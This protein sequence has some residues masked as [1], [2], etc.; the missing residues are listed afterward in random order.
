M[1]LYLLKENNNLYD[2]EEGVIAVCTNVDKCI[3]LMNVLAEEEK[4]SSWDTIEMH[5]D[6]EDKKY[7]Y[8][9]LNRKDGAYR[10][11]EIVECLADDFI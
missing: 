10:S 7:S 9:D 3:E 6:D 11:F 5:V 2:V 1:K 4:D 8:L